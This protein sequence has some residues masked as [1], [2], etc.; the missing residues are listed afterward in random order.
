MANSAVY[1]RCEARGLDVQK[2]NGF[3]FCRSPT[4]KWMAD[5]WIR[6]SPEFAKQLDT[7]LEGGLLPKVEEA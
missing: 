4:S 6:C 3:W 7:M 1:H 2:Q 5:T